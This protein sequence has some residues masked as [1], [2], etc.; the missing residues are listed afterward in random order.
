MEGTKIMSYMKTNTQI[1]AE[2][3]PKTIKSMQP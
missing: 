1:P 3:K 2:I